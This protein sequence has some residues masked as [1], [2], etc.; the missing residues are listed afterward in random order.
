MHVFVTS[1]QTVN[2]SQFFRSANSRTERVTGKK[3]LIWVDEDRAADDS[4][5]TGNGVDY[6]DQH[7]PKDE[8]LFPLFGSV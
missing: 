3:L 8:P 1:C 4:H 6:P 2:S 7:E 5:M